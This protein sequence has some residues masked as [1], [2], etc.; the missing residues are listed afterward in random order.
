MP[1]SRR[2]RSGGG[3]PGCRYRRQRACRPHAG[4]RGRRA[5]AEQL[6]SA[7][8]FDQSRVLELRL[9]DRDGRAVLLTGLTLDASSSSDRIAVERAGARSMRRRSTRVG[10][11][12]AALQDVDRP[13]RHDLRCHNGPRSAR[14]EAAQL[15]RGGC[16]AA[17]RAPQPCRGVGAPLRRRSYAPRS[18]SA[19]NG[20]LRAHSGSTAG[21]H[22]AGSRDSQRRNRAASS[23]APARSEPSGDLAPS[24]H[25]FLPLVGEGEVARP[26]R[27][28]EP[29]RPLRS[30]PRRHRAAR[31]R[32]EGGAR[33]RQ[34]HAFHGGDR[35]DA[36]GS[37]RAARRLR[38]R[39]CRAFARGYTGRAPAPSMPTSTPCV[40][41]PGRSAPP[42]SFEP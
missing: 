1:S 12:R 5:A 4:G 41:C 25:A 19:S 26:D 20:L 36:H 29:G 27:H 9:L 16:G 15:R 32:A 28:S 7:W 39:D 30:P 3:G 21:R 8:L 10:A 24:A 38:G 23:R 11:N 17:R 14:P 33:A 6:C 34:R 37:L 18:P 31:A 22:R 2:I 40:P 42:R 35:L 13:R